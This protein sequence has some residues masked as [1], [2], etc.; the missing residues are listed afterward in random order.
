LPG[1][2]DEAASGGACPHTRNVPLTAW[3]RSGCSV[4]TAQRLY[5]LIRHNGPIADRAFEIQFLDPDIQAYA[6]TFG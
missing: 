1:L 3:D 2:A 5:P 4:V 6:F